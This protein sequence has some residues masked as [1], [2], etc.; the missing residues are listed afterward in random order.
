MVGGAPIV[1]GSWFSLLLCVGCVMS[2]KC[3][4]GLRSDS[5]VNAVPG[6]HQFVGLKG[7]SVWI[8]HVAGRNVGEFPTM[9]K[10]IGAAKAA[11]IKELKARGFAGCDE[12]GES[13]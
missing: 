10:A 13:V 9:A 1:R 4:V 11:R 8:A 6:A 7:K 5:L 2:A 3:F 12:F